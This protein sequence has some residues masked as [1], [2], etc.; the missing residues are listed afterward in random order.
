[1][2]YLFLMAGILMQTFPFAAVGFVFLL[3]PFLI[4]HR[5]SE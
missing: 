4:L 2:H 5:F 3:F 1:M